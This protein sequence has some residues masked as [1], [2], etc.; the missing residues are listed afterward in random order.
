M[1]YFPYLLPKD[2]LSSYTSHLESKNSLN[3]IHLS[4]K[5]TGKLNHIHFWQLSLQLTIISKPLFWI[6]TTSGIIWIWCPFWQISQ[7]NPNHGTKQKLGLADL[8]KIQ[9]MPHVVK[10]QNKGFEI[11][12]TVH[13][14]LPRIPK[15][16]RD[17]ILRN[18][19]DVW[20]N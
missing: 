2:D 12:L 13:I 17:L 19:F 11:K 18:I 5:F 1:V 14:L 8:S 16:D 4:N 10:F 20:Y 3:C 9:V 7:S 6:W 15:W